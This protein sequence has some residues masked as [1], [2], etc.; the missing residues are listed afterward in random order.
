MKV[1]SKLLWLSGAFALPAPESGCPEGFHSGGSIT[2]DTCNL[3]HDNSAS[4]NIEKRLK[5]NVL[6]GSVE[7]YFCVKTSQLNQF[8]ELN[9]PRGSYCIGQKGMV[10]PSGFREGFIKWDDKN[11]WNKNKKKNEL[12]EG[13]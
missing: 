1:N 12:P 3:V 11:V 4:Y 5:V 6:K 7:T 8:E 10:C 9:W 13:K 2:Q